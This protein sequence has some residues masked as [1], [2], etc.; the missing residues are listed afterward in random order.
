MLQNK[1]FNKNSSSARAGAFGTT[2]GPSTRSCLQDGTLRPVHARPPLPGASRLLPAAPHATP[3]P[4][5]PPWHCRMAILLWPSG[6]AGRGRHLPGSAGEG[7]SVPAPAL[8]RLLS[9]SNTARSLQN[10]R[11]QG[12]LMSPCSERPRG[13]DIFHLFAAVTCPSVATRC[14]FPQK[15][16]CRIVQ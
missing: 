6:P 7:W 2:R 8:H 11:S 12:A 1:R 4:R 16:I 14:P 10:K 9:P 5:S 3:P 15:S 13:S